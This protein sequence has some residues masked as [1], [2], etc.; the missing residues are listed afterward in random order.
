M[1][2]NQGTIAKLTG[3]TIGTIK[4]WER[5]GKLHSTIIGGSKLFDIEEVANLVRPLNSHSRNTVLLADIPDYEKFIDRIADD[6]AN[7]LKEKM[8]VIN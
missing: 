2:V 8:N 7:K 6:V 4:E 1:T 3:K 5:Q